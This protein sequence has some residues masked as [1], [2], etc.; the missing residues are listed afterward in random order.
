MANE[1]KTENLVRKHFDKYTDDLIIE[2][3]SS[4]NPKIKKLL[5]TAS[6]SGNGAGY[7]EF[8]IQYK[9]NP[10]LII[11]VECKASITKHESEKRDNPKDFA[12]DGVLLYSSYLAREYDVIAIAVSGET[13]S[14]LKVNHFLQVINRHFEILF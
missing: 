8:I 11:L 4:D 13:A 3:Q 10:D 14:E 7:P 2:E 5:S 12:V 1:R 6:K 9:S